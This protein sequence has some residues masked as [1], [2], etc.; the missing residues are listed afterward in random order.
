VSGRGLKHADADETFASTSAASI[1]AGK[2]FFQNAAKVKRQCASFAVDIRAR[3]SR[4]AALLSETTNLIYAEHK[5]SR[6]PHARQ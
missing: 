2:N 5:V 4:I 3:S 6:A 1:V